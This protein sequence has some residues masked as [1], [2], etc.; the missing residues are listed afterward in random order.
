MI[1]WKEE[2]VIRYSLFGFRDFVTGDYTGVKTKK[3]KTYKEAFLL[4]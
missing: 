2:F 1:S 4:F 3:C